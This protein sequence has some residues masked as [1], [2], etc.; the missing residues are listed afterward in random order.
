MVKPPANPRKIAMDIVEAYF[1]HGGQLK[2]IISKV[3]QDSHLKELDRRFV[4]NLAKGTVRYYL[5]A[6]FF[7]SQLSSRSINK[8]DPSILNILRM[9]VYQAQFIGLAGRGRRR[10]LDSGD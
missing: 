9:G 10:L 4:F 2:E 6:D 5:R 7:I 3:L 8:I 1:S